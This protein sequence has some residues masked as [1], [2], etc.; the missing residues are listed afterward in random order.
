MV[1]VFKTGHASLEDSKTKTP[2]GFLP[3]AFVLSL[4]PLNKPLARL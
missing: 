2:P 3:T 1:A 4:I